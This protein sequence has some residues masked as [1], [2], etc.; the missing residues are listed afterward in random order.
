MNGATILGQ[1]IKVNVARPKNNGGYGGFKVRDRLTIKMEHF[2]ELSLIPQAL[3]Q[4][5]IFA[6]SLLSELPTV[7]Q[8]LEGLIRSYNVVKSDYANELS[9]IPL[10]I[11]EEKS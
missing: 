8:S 5:Q 2:I 1:Q 6:R 10:H 4:R 9:S 3:F 7:N 11:P